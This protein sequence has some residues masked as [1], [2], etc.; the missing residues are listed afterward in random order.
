MLLPVALAPPIAEEAPPAALVLPVLLLPPSETA[1]PV[2][3]LA[4]ALELLPPVVVT[5]ELLGDC[6]PPE[7]C[8]PPNASMPPVAPDLL[9][10]LLLQALAASNAPMSH[11]LRLI[12]WYDMSSRLSCDY[13]AFAALLAATSLCCASI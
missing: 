8:W 7:F 2:P 3:E 6:V 10:L 1:P 4:G 13:V 12:R 5:V 9:S 11:W